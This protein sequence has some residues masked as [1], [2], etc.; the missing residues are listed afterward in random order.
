[1]PCPLREFAPKSPLRSPLF[2]ELLVQTRTCSADCHT[3]PDSGPSHHHNIYTPQPQK[4]AGSRSSQSAHPPDSAWGYQ[5]PIS[6]APSTRPAVQR[7]TDACATFQP[8]SGRRN[9][10]A[11]N[12]KALEDI[13]FPSRR[14]R[15]R[16]R[17]HC[18]RV[19]LMP[20]DAAAA[21][22]ERQSG[23]GQG[24]RGAGPC[25]W[26]GICCF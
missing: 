21:T 3:K 23:A 1:M 20:S 22:A 11:W 6:E 26:T 7:S 9:G 12:A 24:P 2:L 4:L 8:A 19:E 13:F 16:R 14:R 17:R 18:C 5:P 25:L 15:R 10:W